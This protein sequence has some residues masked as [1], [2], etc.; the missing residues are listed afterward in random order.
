MEWQAYNDVE[1][2]DG[3]SRIEYML[4]TLCSI[5][6]NVA[7]AFGGRKGQTIKFTD[8]KDF[9]P[10]WQGMAKQVSKEIT[11]PLEIHNIVCFEDNELEANRIVENVVNPVDADELAQNIKR[12]FG[13]IK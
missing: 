4:A 13:I 12:A 2:L 6:V 10:D 11:A 9:Y 7:R 3:D 8:P 5:I 1:P